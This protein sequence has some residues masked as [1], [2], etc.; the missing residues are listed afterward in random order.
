MR[1]HLLPPELINQIAA[2][3]VVERPASVVKELLENSLD[4]GAHAIEID[5]E[6]GG[7]RLIRVRDDGDGIHPEDLL[8]SLDRHATSKIQHFSDLERVASFGFRGE[9]LSSIASVSRLTLTSRLRNSTDAWCVTS[10]EP[11][12]PAAHPEGTTVEVRDLFYN[13]PARR[14]FLK[15]ARTELGHLEEAI[16]RTALSHTEVGFHLRHQRRTLQHFPAQ[17]QDV[18]RVAAVLGEDFAASAIS[19]EGEANDLRLWGFAGLP[20]AARTQPDQ[21]YFYVNGRTIRDRFIANAVRHAYEGVLYQGRHPAYV[22]FLTIDPEQ[23]DVN[24]HP[25]KHE[26]RFRDGRAVHDFMVQTLRQAI[27]QTRVWTVE[28]PISVSF[29]EEAAEANPFTPA[30]T[31]AS[32]PY[33]AG[34]RE[35]FSPR[36]LPSDERREPSSQRIST[37][38]REPFY[39]ASAGQSCLFTPIETSAAVPTV[40]PLGYAL[41]QLHGIY[42]LAE[43]LHGLVLVDMH[44]AHERITFERLKTAWAEDS[45]RRQP[46]LLPVTLEVG[47]RAVDLAEEHADEIRALGLELERLG[48]GTLVVRQVP[49]LLAQGDAAALVKD[50]LSDFA[51][52]GLSTQVTERVDQ[53]LSS[54]ACH[55]SVRAHRRLSLAEMN[56]LLRDLET[57][58]RCDQCSHGRPTWVQLRLTDLDRLFLRGS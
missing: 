32:R 36:S 44:A 17:Q 10:G 18:H 43:N 20:T 49:T 23:V 14:K 58:E 55:G 13:V 15:S 56:T 52:H 16:R 19:I 47:E 33:E 35:R 40:P 2:G 57:T 30:P 25:T 22:F 5:L 29:A 38:Q 39:G 24:V 45:I 6:E 28:T 1:I 34:I 41:A 37:T 51:E 46:L 53:V 54:M 4:A 8:L 12:R 50:L 21:Q 27:A 9:A 48:R 26:V 11:I 3:E 7:S 31:P 42:V